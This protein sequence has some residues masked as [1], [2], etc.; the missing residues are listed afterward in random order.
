MFR[1]AGILKSILLGYKCWL[2]DNRLWSLTLVKI[3]LTLSP[4]GLGTVTYPLKGNNSFLRNCVGKL[5]VNTIL[6]KVVVCT[7]TFFSYTWRVGFCYLGISAGM[8][9]CEGW[10]MIVGFC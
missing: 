8:I 2:K 4:F 9:G 6:G 1:R 10:E 7:L 3:T 5:W